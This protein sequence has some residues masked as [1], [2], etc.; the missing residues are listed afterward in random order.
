MDAGI[1]PAII[2][3]KFAIFA[4]GSR[5]TPTLV[6]VGSIYTSPPVLTW[7]GQTLWNMLT[8]NVNKLMM[9]EK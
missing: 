1:V 4:P 7:I 2:L 5:Q 8:K 9:T 3:I 6:A